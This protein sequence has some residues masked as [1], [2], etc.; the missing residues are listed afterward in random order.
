MKRIEYNVNKLWIAL[1]TVHLFKW[2]F[3]S[4]N[5]FIFFLRFLLVS[6]TDNEKRRQK[7]TVES[8]E[9]VEILR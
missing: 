7:K 4:I 9:E 1:S 3:T 8:K 5:L 6:D 2:A